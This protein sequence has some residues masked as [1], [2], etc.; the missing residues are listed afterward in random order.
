MKER[1]ILV[2]CLSLLILIGYG[3]GNSAGSSPDKIMKV[4]E[5]KIGMTGYGKTVFQG[6]NIE[7]FGIEVMGVM[8][9][10]VGPKYD[11]ILIKCSHPILE[12]SGIIAGMS[13]S[14]IY[15]VTD[16][17]NEPEGRLIGALAYGWAFCNN[18]MAG[19][20][21]IEMM[22]AD[23]NRPHE[24]ET[25]AIDFDDRMAQSDDDSQQY[26]GMKPLKTPLFV[27][28]VS[29]Q[30]MN[31]LAKA[32]AKH[33]LFPVQG[34]SASS[35][36]KEMVSSEL[37]P[38]SA[39]GVAIV[40]GDENWTGIGTITYRDGDKVS[41]FGHPMDSRGEEVVAPLTNAFIYGI[42]SGLQESFKF[43]SAV[44]EVGV[45]QQDRRSSI[46]GQMYKKAKMLPIKISVENVKTGKKEVF[47]Y[48]VL[49]HYNIFPDTIPTL[50]MNAADSVEVMPFE[51]AFIEVTTNIK[52]KDMDPISIKRL[53]SDTGSGAGCG[54]INNVFN[55]IWQNPYMKVSI[56]NV[57]FEMKVLNENRD[58][59][60]IN[61]WTDV[62]EVVP[63]EM[64]KIYCQLKPHL[65]KTFVKTIDVIIPKDI[66]P[67]QAV[68]IDITGSND[69]M[70]PLPSPT[71]V[72]EII[73][74]MKSFYDGGNLVAVMALPEI[75]LRV[76]GSDYKNLPKSFLSPLI[77]QWQGP[78]YGTSGYDTFSRQ[79]TLEKPLEL[80]QNFVLTVEPL[81]YIISGEGR[82][83]LNVV[84]YKK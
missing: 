57:S 38:G 53:Y 44:E 14:P 51:P 17:E 66:K 71:N 54:A 45:L 37:E 50:M 23:M 9:N 21:P 2:L 13:G 65:K 6:A 42:M 11:M 75:D 48:E 63:G 7:K 1:I 69:I 39:V 58:L 25:S 29:P 84:K 3:V 77:N 16:K 4:D 79:P 15:V 30:R 43:G 61:T 47:N 26:G 56:E 67:G 36:L 70:P 78:L 20:T 40:R 22:I 60:L 52:I 18:N 32:M 68:N 82:I 55:P 74:Y 59:Q 41:A 33:N 31:Y 27:S 73:N 12:K 19:V 28:G 24:K 35:E 8:K 64:V 81:D 62:K 10:G 83:T 34:G 80:A 76:R 72:A 46:S 5:I 49:N